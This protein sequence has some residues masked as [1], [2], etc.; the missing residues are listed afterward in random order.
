MRKRHRKI[1]FTLVELLITSAIIMLLAVIAIPSYNKYNRTRDLQSKAEEVKALLENAVTLSKNN[2]Q[3][4]IKYFITVNS[5]DIEM[6]KDRSTGSV[7]KKVTLTSG[8]SIVS[9]MTCDNCFTGSSVSPTQ[10]NYLI[11]P[12]Q[13]YTNVNAPEKRSYCLWQTVGT[14]GACNDIRST[15]NKTITVVVI[16]DNVSG[17]TA[18]IT[19][20]MTGVPPLT[21]A[22]Y[23]KEYLP[24]VVTIA[25]D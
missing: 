15:V 11:I 9:L 24:V 4:P 7:I 18:I 14:A 3:T 13:S 5:P 8:Q 19:I 1:A 10:G 6:R 2:E 17:K 22:E 12:Y 16:Q 23:M 20:N 25:Y 21:G